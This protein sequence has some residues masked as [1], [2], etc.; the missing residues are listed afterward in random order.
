MWT[1]HS[2]SVITVATIDCSA[3]ISGTVA[4]QEATSEPN[5]TDTCSNIPTANFSFHLVQRFGWSS[6]PRGH[7]S[8]CH[9]FIINGIHRY[10]FSANFSFKNSRSAAMC[11]LHP[12][13]SSWIWHRLTFS[14]TEIIIKKCCLYFTVSWY[15][16]RV[17]PKWQE[18]L[19]WL[20]FEICSYSLTSSFFLKTLVSYMV[21]PIFAAKLWKMSKL[22]R[23]GESKSVTPLEKR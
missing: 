7:L 13:K 23:I 18:Y 16:F 19:A 20:V 2:T 1:V 6:L 14:K 17:T 5:T 9:Q 3:L 21:F 15:Y 8:W 10:Q 11:T 22:I 12:C 4:V